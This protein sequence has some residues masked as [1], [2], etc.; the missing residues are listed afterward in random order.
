[1]PNN[2]CAGSGSGGSVAG[3]DGQVQYN[4]GGAFGGASNLIYND[5]SS[6]VGIGTSSPGMLLSVAGNTYFDSNLITYSS[7]TAANLTISYQRAATSTIPSASAYAWTIATSTTAVPILSFDT[8]G[9]KATSSFVG[10]LSIDNGAFMYDSATGTVSIDSL[11]IGSMGFDEDAG[12]VS[13]IDMNVATTSRGLARSYSAQLDST[14]ILTIYGETDGTGMVGTTSVGIGTTSPKWLFHISGTNP[15]NQYATTSRKSLLAL[16]DS[17]TSNPQ[18]WTMSNQGGVLYFATSSNSVSTSTT[19]ALTV[20]VNGLFGIGTTSPGQQ[21][22]ASGLLLVG[23]SGTS[24]FMN[25]L[26]V[27]GTF[28]AGTGSIYAGEGFLNFNTK[29]TSTIPSASA[30]AWTIA[31]STTAVP[32]LSFDTWGYKATSSFVGSLSIDN[33]AFMYDSAT[34]TVSIDSLST[35]PMAFDTD[36]G[37]LSWV[38]MPV[39]TTTSGINMSY[40]AMMDASSTASLT[41]YGRTANSGGINSFG[42]GIGTTTPFLSLSVHSSPNVQEMDIGVFNG[43]IC[44]DNNGTTKCYGALTAGTVYG[45]TGTFAASDVAENYPVYDTTVEAGDI[46]AIGP[47]VSASHAE[48]KVSFNGNEDGVEELLSSAALVKADTQ[49]QERIIGIISTRPGVLLGDATGIKLETEI[50][51]V[52]LSGRVPV[53]VNLESGEIKIGDQ[54]VISSVAG[55]GKK[56]T[57]SGITVGVALEGFDGWSELPDGERQF[58]ESGVVMVFANLGYSKLDD[59]VSGM[60]STGSADN[61]LSGVEGLLTNAWSV[62]QTSGK[63]NVGFYGDIDMHGNNILNVANIISENGKW[64]I[65]EDGIIIAN[66]VITDE[67]VT[68]KLTV[69]DAATFGSVAKPIGLTVYDEATGAEYCMKVRNGAVVAAAGSC[70][71]AQ[72]NPPSPEATDG[73]GADNSPPSVILNESEGSAGDS[74][75]TSS[76]Q[77]DV[78]PEVEPPAG[79]STSPDSPPSEVPSAGASEAPPEVEPSPNVEPPPAETPLEP[80]GEGLTGQAASSTPAT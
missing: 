43:S 56:A 42:I 47:D 24:T 12:M 57:S 69:N 36:A 29:T 62:D 48:E 60:A 2:S 39:S 31:T 5:T 21:L 58:S 46:V 20:T 51:P 18:T 49:N 74:S 65:S 71:I 22:S 41:V 13:W 73:Q 38:D 10:S 78:T 53:K 63:V 52:A 28:Q 34:G 3:S 77:N 6:R 40:S 17:G 26:Q 54:I 32:I 50:K 79:G 30:Y 16:T 55:V 1:M 8:W 72:T 23:G 75:A 15:A 19:P 33:G 35:G 61:S 68:N 45:D 25:N 64:S 9:Y 70:S 66:R 11:N 14:S 80:S 76:P 44:A 27:R 37:V 59:A 4:D 7:S 67:L